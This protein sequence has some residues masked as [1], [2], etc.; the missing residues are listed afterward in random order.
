MLKNRTYLLL[1]GGFGLSNLGNWIYLI[2]LNLSVWHLTHSPAAVAGLYI[3]GPCARIVSN[4]FVGS[5]I[6]R[7]NKRRIIIS[8]DIIRGLM[9]CIMPFV[10]SLWLVYSLIAVTSIAGSFFGPS[11]TYMIT[12]LVADE[13]KQRF[14]ALNSTLSSGSF[15]IGP[16]LAGAIIL[17]TNTSVAM[18][19]NGVT[20]FIC[21]LLMAL[22][23]KVENSTENKREII[24]FNVIRADFKQVWLYVKLRPAL[25]QFLLVYTITLMIAY[26]LDS[27]EMTFIKDV[28]L[29]TDSLYGVI[30][31]IAGV[32]AI[33]GGL[34]AAA[35]A[36]VYSLQSYIGAGFTLTLLSYFSF[37]A[38]H[39]I[40]FAIVSFIFLGFFM[41]FSDAGYAT[42]YQKTIPPEMM[43]R[44]GG[45]LNLLQ[46]ILQ[47]AITLLIGFLA[48]WY[49]VQTVTLVFA[50]IGFVLALYV[51][52]I[53]LRSSTLFDMEEN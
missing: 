37:Y 53:V 36:N 39:T 16:A 38:S 47:I 20:F 52:R 21:A 1:I 13:H 5:I 34:C 11:S 30:V 33:I 26:S 7:Y 45:S 25:F 12:K 9:V 48:E 49:S 14:N 3:V 23:P 42:F 24:T 46:S 40:W 32:G 44:F 22:L 41:A 51:Y 19:I 15:M 18:W 43:G 8:S 10:D 4:F 27:Q 28:L 35:L 2:A 31:S 50:G 6:D 17:M 29:A